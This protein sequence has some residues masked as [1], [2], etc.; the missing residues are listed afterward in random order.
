MDG[1]DFRRGGFRPR[2]VAFLLLV[3]WQVPPWLVVI[4]GALAATL[5][6]AL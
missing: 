5:L 1:S 4:F 3:I 6:A 2:I